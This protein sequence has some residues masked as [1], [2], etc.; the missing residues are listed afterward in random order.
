MPIIPK[1]NVTYVK[2][3]PTCKIRDPTLYV[4]TSIQVLESSAAGLSIPFQK[5][6]I[7]NIRFQSKSLPLDSS[8]AGIFK[9]GLI[10]T[11]DEK[12]TSILTSPRRHLAL[13]ELLSDI[14]L[15]RELPQKRCSTRDFCSVLHFD[16][17]FLIKIQYRKL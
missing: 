15:N 16:K 12:P 1:E 7:S 11:S 2:F 5:C 14:R 8:A 4:P 17:C 10:K 13:P 9:R 3:W 6:L